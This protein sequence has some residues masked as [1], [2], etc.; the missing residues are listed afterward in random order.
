MRAPRLDDHERRERTY[1]DETRQRIAEVYAE[2]IDVFGYT[3]D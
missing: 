3:Y 1:T 2:D